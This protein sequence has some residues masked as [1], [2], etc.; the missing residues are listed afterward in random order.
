MK[1]RRDLSFVP[2][3]SLDVN[4][5]SSSYHHLDYT[6]QPKLSTYTYRSFD[7]RFDKMVCSLTL[8]P[9]IAY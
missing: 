4:V 3:V 1:V 8:D 5:K 6:F 9:K 7:T 2:V